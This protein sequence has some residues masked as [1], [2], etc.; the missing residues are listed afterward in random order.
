MCASWS[1]GVF[2]AVRTRLEKDGPNCSRTSVWR[3]SGRSARTAPSS[4]VSRTLP[5]EP[6][7]AHPSLGGLLTRT[8]SGGLGRGLRSWLSDRCSDVPSDRSSRGR[9]CP[10]TTC[11]AG[12]PAQLPGLECLVS[13][14]SFSLSALG[15]DTTPL[16]S[17]ASLNSSTWGSLKQ[18]LRGLSIEFALL[19]DKAAQQV[20]DVVV[21]GARSEEHLS[22]GNGSGDIFVRGLWSPVSGVSG[23]WSRLELHVPM[24]SEWLLVSP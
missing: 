10:G 16:P 14:V 1:H 12:W 2:P 15:S 5:R 23:C 9:G 4:S 11:H 8:G 17:W 19:A 13:S 24:C 22:L 7:C 6:T 3:G 18:A 21:L 20:S